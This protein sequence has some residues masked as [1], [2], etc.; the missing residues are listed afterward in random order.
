MLCANTSS[1]DLAIVSTH[2]RLPLKSGVR[3]STRILDFLL[4]IS[5][6]VSAKWAEPPSGKSI[7][8]RMCCYVRS[9]FV[10]VIS[11]PSLSTE[12]NTT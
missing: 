8:K 12:V 1:P 5:F 6:T 4:L 9:D 3:H 2:S 11:V 10:C 7:N